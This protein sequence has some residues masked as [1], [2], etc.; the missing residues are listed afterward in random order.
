MKKVLL[1]YGTGGHAEQMMRLY[2]VLKDLDDVKY[3][4]I[5]EKGNQQINDEHQNIEFVFNTPIRQKEKKSI[6]LKYKQLLCAFFEGI[7]NAIRLLTKHKIKLMISTGPG[8]AIP[9]ALICR[10]FGCRVVHIETWSRFYCKSITG[11]YMYKIASDFWIQNKELE[12]IYPKAKF[13]G[14]L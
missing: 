12:E 10:L 9:T 8:I 13:V 5:T 4:A 3:Y 1:V 11:K 6:Y 2:D 14:R 7:N